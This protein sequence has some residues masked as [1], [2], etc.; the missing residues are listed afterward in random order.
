[1]A[2][3]HKARSCNGF[4]HLVSHTVGLYRSIRSIH[5]RFFPFISSS[6][7]HKN[8]HILQEPYRFL[9]WV[10]FPVS[11][12]AQSCHEV[13]SHSTTGA[14]G[15]RTV[16]ACQI[17]FLAVEPRLPGLREP[18]YT[19]CGKPSDRRR[20]QAGEKARPLSATHPCDD[21]HSRLRSPAC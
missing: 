11:S 2:I 8:G 6:Y 16:V 1:M 18:V 4:P 7:H 5:S 17:L 12:E 15:A 9:P 10:S 14:A 21:P 3:I 20:P 13:I 19:L